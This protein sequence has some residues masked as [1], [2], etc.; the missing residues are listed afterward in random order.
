MKL[1]EYCNKKETSWHKI[2][3]ENAEKL[4]KYI[5]NN[6]EDDLFKVA[7]TN[8]SL[9]VFNKLKVWLFKF[10]NK[11]LLD[12]LDYIGADYERFNKCLIYSLILGITRNKSNTDLLYDI[13]KDANIIE[14]MLVYDD[15]V[16]EIISR[17]FGKIQFIKADDNFENDKETLD[18]INKLGENIQDGCHEI[19]FYLIQKYEMFKAVTSICK[20]GIDN[21]YY[22]SF[23]LDDGNNV[24]DFTA[25]VIMPKNQYYLLQE[26][27]ELNRINYKEYLEEKDKSI[28]FDES[29]TMYD[30]LRN[31]VY[32][33]YLEENNV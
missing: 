5:N 25:N 15:G 14:K 4:I 16:Y 29:K 20:K 24:I 10:Y 17:N 13:L 26:V 30:L 7:N 1:S 8:D 23:I 33:Q 28:E 18:F 22:H 9:E 27:V 3:Q 32:K 6:I 21:S 11:Q 31:A 19:S 2:E 12:G